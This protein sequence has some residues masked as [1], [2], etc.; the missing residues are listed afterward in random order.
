MG[1]F[2]TASPKELL[3]AR[4]RLFIGKCLPVLQAHGFEKSPFQGSWFG[5]NNLNDY[6]YELCRL[7]QGSHLEIFTTHL[8]RGDSWIKMF[9]NIF[10]LELSP[11]NLEALKRGFHRR[12]DELG[13]VIARDLNNI[14]L[15]GSKWH[16]LHKVATTNWEGK[17]VEE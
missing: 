5:R 2:Y 3:E 17:V 10:K 8:S 9:L 15:I 1:L 4:N 7:T 6:S 14:D 13:V 16:Q 11:E 12:L